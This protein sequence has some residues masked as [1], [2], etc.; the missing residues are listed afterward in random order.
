M[1]YPPDEC[2]AFQLFWA[3]HKR[4]PVLRRGNE[5][6]VSLCPKRNGTATGKDVG[7]WGHS[8]PV[9]GVSLEKTQVTG[10]KKPIAENLVCKKQWARNGYSG[11]KDGPQRGL[12]TLSLTFR[13]TPAES[14][15]QDDPPLLLLFSSAFL[16]FQWQEYK[17]QIPST[18]TALDQSCCHVDD[19]QLPY[20]T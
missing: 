14:I 10:G 18:S 8:L 19:L 17:A 4:R 6:K 15:S 11:Y 12:G 2:W 16:H 7:D 3:R 9:L 1:I 5:S 20:P 13:W